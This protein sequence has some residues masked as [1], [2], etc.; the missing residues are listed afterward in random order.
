MSRRVSQQIRE[1]QRGRIGGRHTHGARDHA[2]G[3]G[4][5]DRHG[6]TCVPPIGRLDLK[7]L[8]CS[9]SLPIRGS[10]PPRIR[11]GHE[12]DIEIIAHAFLSP[13]SWRGFQPPAVKPLGPPPPFEGPTT[14]DTRE[15][16]TALPPPRSD[17][18][19]PHP[20]FPTPH[21]WTASATRRLPDN[22]QPKTENRSLLLGI[23]PSTRGLTTPSLRST[24][25]VGRVQLTSCL[26]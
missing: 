10:W 26:G 3:A 24:L 18:R 15:P 20:E 12:W 5:E 17:L 23:S 22:P 11:S 1:E 7:L 9:R 4:G 8:P 6:L 21:S 14:I 19:I 25:R 16:R 2:W 13:S